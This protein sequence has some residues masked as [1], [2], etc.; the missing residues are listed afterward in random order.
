[1]KRRGYASCCGLTSFW[2]LHSLE[3]SQVTDWLKQDSIKETELHN[4][5]VLCSLDIWI[6]YFLWWHPIFDPLVVILCLFSPDHRTHQ[7][8]LMWPVWDHTSWVISST[9]F[10]TLTF[11]LSPCQAI[12]I[13][14]QLP[15][16]WCLCVLTNFIAVSCLPH[17]LFS[18]PPARRRVV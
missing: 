14:L 11:L 17:T 3:R 7:P 16:P 15:P 6:S 12:S 13:N 5:C 8:N 18:F 9:L 1:M 2:S 4:F 10:K